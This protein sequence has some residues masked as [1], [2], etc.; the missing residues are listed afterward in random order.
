[1]QSNQQSPG[2]LSQAFGQA[3]QEQMERSPRLALWLLQRSQTLLERFI[4]FY[5]ALNW[6][7]RWTQRRWQ[8]KLGASLAGVA[9][10]L[11]LNGAPALYAA[12][13]TVTT[14]IPAINDGDGLCS[15]IEAIVNANDDSALYA[16]CAPGSGADVIT[17]TGGFYGLAGKHEGDSALPIIT[18]AITI[19]GNGATIG[20]GGSGLYR[21]LEVA[22]TGDLTLND[23]TI[24]GGAHTPG[25]GIFNNG[26]I[27]ALNN[28]TV[29]GN[30]NEFVEGGGIL[31]N[32]GTV[33]LNNSAV[34][35]NVARSGGGIVNNSGAMTLHNST[36]S[37]NVA[38]FWNGAGIVNRGTMTLSNSTVSNNRTSGYDSGGIENHNTLT[39]TNSTVS[40]N[41][42]DSGGG[43]RNVGGTA[44]LVN[45][46]IANSVSGGD[47]VRNGGTINAS[48]SL[49]E[50]GL[51]CVNGTNVNNLTGDPNVGPL[52]D[53]DGPTFTHDLLD[54][55]PAIDAGDSAAALDA[56][57]QPLTTD[58]RGP[59]FPRI[60]GSAVDIGAVEASVGCLP[61]PRSVAD[62]TELD[63]AIG[64]FNEQSAPGEYVITLS[65]DIA[66]DASTPA[67]D[68]ADPGVSLRIEG[69][70][71]TVDGQN[72]PGVRPFTIQRNTIV[73][74][75]AI[76]IT[77]GAGPDADGGGGILN[78]GALTVSHSNI[79]SNT[80]A[81]WG[82]GITN[83]DGGALNL[84]HS[85][86]SGNETTAAVGLGGGIFSNSTVHVVNSTLRDNSAAGGG[87]IFSDKKALSVVNSTIHGNNGPLGGGGIIN[88]GGGTLSV[89]N[90]TLS[91]NHTTDAGGAILNADNSTASII[92][93]TLSDNSAASGGGLFTSGTLVTLDNTI[94]A[95]SL[96]GGDCVR[97]SGALDASHSLIEGGLSCVNGTNTNNLTG[98]PNLGPLQDNGGPTFTHALLAGSPAINQGDNT[99]CVDPA[100][101]NNLDQ[102][103]I[104]RP[105]GAACDIGAFELVD[106][107]PPTASPT[108]APPANA[109]GWNNTDVTVTW[110]W[111]DNVDG[112][113]IDP[114]NCT[115]ST[116]SSVE[117]EIALEATCTDLAGN[118]GYGSYTTFIDK[119]APTISAAA[120]SAPNAAGWY[121]VAVT[122]EFTCADALS[123]I[124][125]D[126]CPASQTLDGEGAAIASAP[127]TV[128]DNA[129]NTSDPSNVVIVQID[130]TPPLVT[131]TG[132]SEGGV[133]SLESAPAPGCETT[134]ALSGVATAATVG[135]SGGAGDGTGDFTATCSDAVD[136][137]GNETPPASVSYRIE[138]A[139]PAETLDVVV[140]GQEGVR[141]GQKV[142]VHSGAVVANT[143]SMGPFLDS[144]VELSIGQESSFLGESSAY[145]DSVKVIQRS[146][147][148]TV[149]Y[150]HLQEGQQVS[151]G[152]RVTPLTLPVVALPAF[153]AISP[154]GDNIT[155][156]QNGSLT[157]AAGRYGLF[158]V[159]QKATVIFG[160]GEY[161]FAAWEVGQQVNL[162]FQA[163]S[164]IRIAGRLSVGQKSVVGPHPSA[165]GL[166]AQDIVL[167]VAG[168][169]GG[170][171][172]LS[173]SPKAAQ[174]G[175]ESTLYANIYA[176]N[177][178]LLVYQKSTVRGAL[179]ARWVDIGQE[180]ALTFGSGFVTQYAVNGAS[181]SSTP[182]DPRHAGQPPLEEMEE[183]PHATLPDKQQETETATPDEE[184]NSDEGAERTNHT[185]L[186]I[187]TR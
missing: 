41:R 39:L 184:V 140:L 86:L 27:L 173:G 157:L 15:L 17:L 73:V 168:P 66:L 48:H 143:P 156:A 24:T 26:G 147:I 12:D 79:L 35:G 23:T 179:L 64:C 110:N 178:T 170:N 111:A 141:L 46:I 84:I 132:V 144:G 153:P 102:R 151:I 98:D 70:G 37:G 61:F 182:P 83:V 55:S 1:M 160:G 88:A 164:E 75:Q 96:G 52:Q 101:V 36:V 47:C 92:N 69:A 42:A 7:P 149:Y 186:P 72:I 9:L 150:N 152:Q 134:D 19:Q 108:Q 128:T 163:P 28:S 11:A 25:A 127:Q 125:V 50:G 54:S 116:T 29:S 123:G 60:R 187:V 32:G 33:T 106:A 177:G 97:L 30:T 22:G 78:L 103:G 172:T 51:G 21:I 74:M 130:H 171:G 58:Q 90:S 8:R 63:D 45:T 181:M 133:Y 135:V 49:I 112:S 109:N 68:N 126:A 40:G 18:S 165:V 80:T 62:S 174:V 176:P 2:E 65:D 44:T 59:G 85:T 136:M 115:A 13:I 146:V 20:R 14:A 56:L 76:T 131:V 159:N 114:A 113:G 71:H 148:P 10:A 77:R 155:V 57:G 120:T 162:Y 142:I 34:S 169:N 139:P 99:V 3:L 81:N 138:S 89:V 121:N 122:V 100:T 167:Y 53:N 104:T 154:G 118:G 43:L 124:P 82:G 129:G 117:G 166:G 4:H 95:N 94:I 161:H 31:N 180:V 183:G 107:T 91:D 6:L 38:E 67:I 158:K 175:Q 93:S 137:A 87:A 105:Q 185:F 119:T 16:D 145:G 5:Q